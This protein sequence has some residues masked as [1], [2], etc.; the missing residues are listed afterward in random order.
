MIFAIIL[1]KTAINGFSL[2]QK[3]AEQD[4]LNLLIA[5][6]KYISGNVEAD[7]RTILGMILRREDEYYPVIYAEMVD[8]QEGSFVVPQIGDL[9]DSH[10]LLVE[11]DDDAI[12]ASCRSLGIQASFLAAIEAVELVYSGKLG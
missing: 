9:L 1:V 7:E 11:A 3:T 2:T 5:G 12:D 6:V 8:R 4:A 10:V